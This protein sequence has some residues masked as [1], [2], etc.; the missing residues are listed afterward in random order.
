MNNLN[1]LDSLDSIRM[2]NGSDKLK[3]HFHDLV[4]NDRK[5]AIDSINNENLHFASL[6]LLRSEIKDSNLLNDLSL[7]NRI[8]LE[9][10]NEIVEKEKDS[11][12]IKYISSDY[13]QIVYSILKWIFETGSMDDGLSNKYDEVLDITAILL[14]RIYNDQKILPRVADMI[15]AR[16]KKGFF[17]HDLVW[18]FF[19]CKDPSSLIMIA[20]R[21]L[22]Q[23]IDDVNLASNLLSFV[24]GIDR[25][26]NSNK[27][28]QYVFF[29][30]WIEENGLFLNFTGQSLQEVNRPR[31]Y[32]VDLEAKYLRKFVSVES[33]KMLK[34]LTL[35]E[36]RLLNEFNGLDD[37]TKL[38]LSSFSNMLNNKDINLWNKWINY[39]IK[40]QIEI[41]KD[42]TGGVQ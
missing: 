25:N 12:V 33:G 27:Q 8:A 5:K 10:V 14:T 26:N 4:K 28:R 42:S 41:A 15:F 7:R 30:K 32:V 13:T 17:I 39:P 37:N 38:L 20:N 9:I 36:K 3:A 16:N 23:E 11:S 31:P 24:P 34:P 2:N 18:A 29:L 19:E 22:S 40:K 35:K 1:T 21:L 6:F